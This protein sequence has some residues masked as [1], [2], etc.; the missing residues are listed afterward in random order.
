MIAIIASIYSAPLEGNSYSQR[1][2]G[3]NAPV[4][5]NDICGVGANSD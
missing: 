1:K 2:G 4:A 5:L 3:G